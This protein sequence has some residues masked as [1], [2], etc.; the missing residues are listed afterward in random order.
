MTLYEMLLDLNRKREVTHT[1]KPV[2]SPQEHAV[3]NV[4]ND[5]IGKEMDTAEIALNA[6]THRETTLKILERLARTNAL[7]A[8]ISSVPPEKQKKGLHGKTRVKKWTCH[9]RIV[10]RG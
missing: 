1:H 2:A 4:L 10:A 6:G 9:S 3:I 8:R 7:T 5:Y